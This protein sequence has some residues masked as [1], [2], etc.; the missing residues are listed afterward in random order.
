MSEHLQCPAGSNRKLIQMYP[1][2]VISE[3]QLEHEDMFFLTNFSALNATVSHIRT[4]I[5]VLFS[6]SFLSESAFVVSNIPKMYLRG[7][8]ADSR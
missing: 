7:D 8:H 1:V 4:N 5:N 6:V 2:H 3:D